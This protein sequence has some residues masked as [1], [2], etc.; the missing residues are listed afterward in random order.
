MLEL[1]V[2][3]SGCG[4]EIKENDELVYEMN[5][6]MATAIIN[7][8]IA[9][10]ILNYMITFK[11]SYNPT[12]SIPLIPRLVPSSVRLQILK[13]WNF[14]EKILFH[15]NIKINADG[16]N[17]LINGV[18]DIHVTLLEGLYQKTMRLK[19]IKKKTHI[20]MLNAVSDLA[21]DGKL[22]KKKIKKVTILS[23]K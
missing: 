7:G 16:K 4:I 20:K 10:L 13:N 17:L 6:K 23:S 18:N 8:N 15:F 12:K 2:I 19:R 5:D 11:N 3:R 9:R 21:F 14:L 22:K 1:P